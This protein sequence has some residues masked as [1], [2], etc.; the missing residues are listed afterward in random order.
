M[1]IEQQEQRDDSARQGTP[2]ANDMHDLQANR[3]KMVRGMFQITIGLIQM[4]GA[5]GNRSRS[6]K[7]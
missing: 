3:R 2:D 6:G 4:A 1:R 5:V 7:E